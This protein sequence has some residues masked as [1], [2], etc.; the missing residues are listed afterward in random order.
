MDN[1]EQRDVWII[2]SG[3]CYEHM[4]R[5]DNLI[6]SDVISKDGSATDIPTCSSEGLAKYLVTDGPMQTKGITPNNIA[7]P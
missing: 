7:C 1:E 5:G 2:Y 3:A 6:Q 4:E